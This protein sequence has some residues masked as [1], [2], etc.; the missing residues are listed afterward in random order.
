MRFLAASSVW[1]SNLAH[2]AKPVYS[3]RGGMCKRSL[4]ECKHPSQNHT[5]QH[6]E[7]KFP[8]SK[9]KK[10]Q[11]PL[12]SNDNKP[13]PEPLTNAILSLFFISCVYMYYIYYLFYV[14][15]QYCAHI[16]CYLREERTR[17][18]AK[19]RERD[20]VST[21]RAGLQVWPIALWP[22]SYF[23]ALP[24]YL[25]LSFVSSFLSSLILPHTYTPS[26]Q[27]IIHTT[28][29]MQQFTK[30]VYCHMFWLF[31]KF[32]CTVSLNQYFI[33]QVQASIG[34]WLFKAVQ[35]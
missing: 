4:K 31:A 17:E 14:V 23:I 9:K 10:R 30:C 3:C 35:Y 15:H 28:T 13:H 18:T 6:T 32:S 22:Y 7:G 1:T 2:V 26:T 5:L 24:F 21:P 25:L 27:A 16:S 33:W 20:H 11:A 12:K 19:D 8:L 29:Y 34:A